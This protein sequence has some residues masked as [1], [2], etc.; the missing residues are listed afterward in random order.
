MQM[1]N[2]NAL[3][4][5]INHD[6]LRARYCTFLSYL[7][8]HDTS[9]AVRRNITLQEMA[10]IYEWWVYEPKLRLLLVQTKHVVNPA[11]Y[12]TV[13]FLP[14]LNYLQIENIRRVLSDWFQSSQVNYQIRG[15][16]LLIDEINQQLVNTPPSVLASVDQDFWA[17]HYRKCVSLSELL[18][19][20]P[21]TMQVPP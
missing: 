19:S 11:C 5:R 12:C 20:M 2:I 9:E 4:S 15:A 21:T 6:W 7:T 10:R 8:T 14:E 16:S 17:A 3:R 18:S 1:E 13:H